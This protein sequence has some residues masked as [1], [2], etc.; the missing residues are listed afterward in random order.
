MKELISK[1][2]SIVDNAFKAIEECGLH[3]V[4]SPIRGGTDGANLTYM[5][6]PCPNLG[7]GGFN[8]HGPFEFV[9][10]TMMRKQVEVLLKI[11]ENTQK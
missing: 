2:M 4:A 10:V 8:Y 5:G 3:P 9:S 1:D 7:T 11:I 6:L